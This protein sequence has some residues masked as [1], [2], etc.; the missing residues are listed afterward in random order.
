MSKEYYVGNPDNNIL[1]IGNGFDLHH[2][3]K[4]GYK[5]FMKFCK[6]VQPG[7]DEEIYRLINGNSFIEYFKES[8]NEDNTWIDLE[9]EIEVITRIFEQIFKKNDRFNGKLNHIRADDIGFIKNN[10]FYKMEKFNKILESNFN[11]GAKSYI[12]KKD[13]QK[14]SVYNKNLILEDLRNMLGDVTQAVYI[15]LRDYSGIDKPLVRKTTQIVNIKP[16][17]VINFNY[18]DTIKKYGVLENNISYIHGKISDVNSMVLGT[19]KTSD[20]FIYFCKYFQRLQKKCDVIDYNKFNKIYGD[21]GNGIQCNNVLHLY[22]H[23]L[24]ITDGD[25]I[26]SLFEKSAKVKMYYKDQSDYESKIINL[27][28]IYEDK[29]IVINMFNKNFIEPIEILND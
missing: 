17:Y 6:D 8:Y 12:I 13:Y 7:D 2:N 23:S 10:D 19:Q 11:T 22:G 4:T 28:R 25:I 27:F 5:D 3:Y 16:D 21:N 15:Y 29:N 20:N 18:T 14:S 1:L 24:D 9:N 26:A